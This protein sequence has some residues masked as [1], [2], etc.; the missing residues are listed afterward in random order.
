MKRLRVRGGLLYALAVVWLV[1][2]VTLS[3]WWLVFGLSQAREL[4]KPL[5]QR[6][7]T[8]ERVYRMLIGEGGVLIGLLVAGGAALVIGIHYE[9]K[10]Q[11]ALESFFMVF[12]HE[13]KTSLARVQLQAE[14]LQEELPGVSTPVLDRLLQDAL[15]LQLQL[16]NSLF[17]AQPDGRLLLESIDAAELVASAAADF[18]ALRVTTIGTGTVRGDSRA[19]RSVLRNVLHNAVAH[20]GATEVTVAIT[21]ADRGRVRLRMSDNGRGTS[22]EIVRTIGAPFDGTRASGNT[23]FG[24]YVSRQLVQRMHGELNWS[25]GTG[26]HPGFI[27][28]LAL[29]E[30]E[31]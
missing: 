24:L 13:V 4:A 25:V 29:A 31:P 27:V 3:A 19:L 8:S 6:T 17:F 15:R 12:T 7:M 11:A 28:D 10:R 30:R 1:L 16:E 2:T 22:P 21:P 20:G 23:G 18:P 14:S 26:D 5:A 9:Q